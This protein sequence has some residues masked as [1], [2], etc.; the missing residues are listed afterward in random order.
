MTYK[1]SSDIRQS[2]TYIVAGKFKGDYDPN[3]N[4]LEDKSKKAITIL[5]N[6]KC[7]HL[8]AV[9]VLKRHIDVNINGKCGKP[10]NGLDFEGA[11][12]LAD[13]LNW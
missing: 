10:C 4:Y 5:S 7:P 13:H 6:Y 12:D 1:F 11:V 8:L 3:R 2:Y 9:R